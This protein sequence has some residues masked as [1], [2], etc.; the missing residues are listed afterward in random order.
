MQRCRW[1][2]RTR[3]AERSVGTDSRELV[4]SPQLMVCQAM[5]RSVEEQSV[6]WE[7]SGAKSC[8]V[9]AREGIYDIS[10]VG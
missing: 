3:V 2:G 7:L 9:L 5:E 10:G 8:V 6:R 1:K 4:I